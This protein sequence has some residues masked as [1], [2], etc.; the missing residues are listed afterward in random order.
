MSFN[1]SC[2]FSG[3]LQGSRHLR[4]K[5]ADIFFGLFGKQIQISN[6]PDPPRGQVAPARRVAAVTRQRPLT[7]RVQ[8]IHQL[9]AIIF[10]RLAPSLLHH[11]ANVDLATAAERQKH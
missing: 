11:S 6:F 5:S 1:M 10:C 9:A 7:S 8:H 2:G 4:N 3:T